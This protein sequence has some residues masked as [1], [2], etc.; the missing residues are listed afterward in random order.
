[1][2]GTPRWACR[3]DATTH[4]SFMLAGSWIGANSHDVKVIEKLSR[5]DYRAVETLLQSAQ[6]PE[7]PWIHRGQEWLC[8]SRQFV[9]RQ[10]AGKITETMLVDFHAVVRDV[11]GEEDPSLQLPLEQRNM[12][13]ILGKARKYS[14]SLRRGLV[15]AVARLATLRADGQKWADRIVQ[16][17]L[18]PEHPRAFER[19][20]SLADV[21]SEIAE[22]SPNVFFN[23]L[24]EMLKRNDAVRFFQDREANDV[25]FSPTSAHV[26]L[27][28][29]LER[30]AWQNEHFSRVLGILARLAEIDPGGK[31]SNRPMNS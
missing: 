12:A 22:A 29:A 15:D 9:W 1:P 24:E 13:E 20:L 3:E 28:W 19:W 6:I 10:L 27:L 8:A 11:L 5:Q 26:F 21:F 18:D 7:G 16:T 30:L 17:L 25:L 31:T 4:A 14:R 2:V 23:T